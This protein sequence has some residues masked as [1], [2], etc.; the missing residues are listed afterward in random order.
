[1]RQIELDMVAA[2]IE[3]RDWE[4]DNTRVIWNADRTACHVMLWDNLIA[5]LEGR[6]LTLLDGGHRT[7]TTKSRLNALNHAFGLP[8]IYQRQGVWYTEVA[9]GLQQEFTVG[10]HWLNQEYAA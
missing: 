3:R 1:M 9:P 5:V 4:K 7:N 8:L 6:E 2:V 10:R